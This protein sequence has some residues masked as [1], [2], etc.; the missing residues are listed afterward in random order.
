M[1]ARI[2]APYRLPIPPLRSQQRAFVSNSFVAVIEGL[3][4]TASIRTSN[5][6]NGAKRDARFVE[7]GRM[8]NC[9]RDAARLVSSDYG[10][11]SRRGQRKSSLERL[12]GS[13]IPND[14][15]NYALEQL[16]AEWQGK[17]EPRPGRPN[18]IAPS[19]G[20]SPPANQN[21]I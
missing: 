8:K 1:L 15:C 7:D 17:S 2:F 10:W 12:H 16:N 3:A 6:G 14:P 20:V 21:Y 5:V 19:D 13:R 18:Q 11:S 4:E 9:R